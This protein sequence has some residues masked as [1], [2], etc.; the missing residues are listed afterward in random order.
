MLL[1]LLAF[2]RVIRLLRE[3]STFVNIIQETEILNPWKPI[4]NGGLLQ[5]RVVASPSGR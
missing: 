5:W 2:R 3:D 4:E 1:R